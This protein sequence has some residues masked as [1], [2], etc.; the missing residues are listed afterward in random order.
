LAAVQAWDGGWGYIDPFGKMIIPPRFE[1]ANPFNEGQASVKP[2]GQDNW[3]IINPTGQTVVRLNREIQ[4]VDAFSEGLVSVMI[5]DCYGDIDTQGNL[6][7][8]LEDFE[9]SEFHQGYAEAFVGLVKTH[10]DRR[11][12]MLWLPDGC[13]ERGEHESRHTIPSRNLQ[14]VG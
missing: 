6:A 12:R 13:R 4:G 7:F 11:G 2:V 9:S 1:E 3:E 14:E 5:R 10:I 8:P